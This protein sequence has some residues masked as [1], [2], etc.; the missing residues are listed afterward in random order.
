MTLWCIKSVLF[1]KIWF[2]V[3]QATSW[4]SATILSTSAPPPCP[5]RNRSNRNE[6]LLINVWLL[7]SYPFISPHQHHHHF[8]LFLDFRLRDS[9]S[10]FWTKVKIYFDWKSFGSQNKRWRKEKFAQSFYYFWQTCLL[11][12]A[13][14]SCESLMAWSCQNLI[15]FNWNGLKE[16]FPYKIRHF[17][18]GGGE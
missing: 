15:C 5:L 17:I 11:L 13:L 16:R 1:V 9:W 14:F 6:Y 4:P 12:K 8:L 2:E 3:S 18:G 7:T 10:L